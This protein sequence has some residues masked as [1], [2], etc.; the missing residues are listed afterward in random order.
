MANIIVGN[1]LD[2]AQAQ[3][4]YRLGTI[5][6]PNLAL[7]IDTQHQGVRQS[8]GSSPAAEL[9]FLVSSQGEGWFGASSAHGAT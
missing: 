7:F 6:G 1:A 8:T 4:Q 5:E 3:G 9:G 2:V